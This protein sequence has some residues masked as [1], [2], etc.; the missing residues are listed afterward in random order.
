MLL[1]YGRS[2]HIEMFRGSLLS[3]HLAQDNTDDQNASHVILPTVTMLE[4]KERTARKGEIYKE[5]RKKGRETGREKEKKEE[6]MS[7][8][9]LYKY[10]RLS[11]TF[12]YSMLNSRLFR[13]Y[14]ST[15]HFREIRIVALWSP[16]PPRPS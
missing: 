5:L 7:L 9:P 16:Y 3:L 14:L 2:E 1:A 15:L 11:K 8:L 6:R 4:Y 10:P 13:V 12:E